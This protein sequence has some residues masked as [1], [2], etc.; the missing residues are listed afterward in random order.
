M[1]ISHEKKRRGGSRIYFFIRSFFLSFFFE[2]FLLALVGVPALSPVVGAFACLRGVEPPVESD[3]LRFS[4]A[5]LGF[6]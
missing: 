3:F 2:D 5:G 1:V 6:G 4:T